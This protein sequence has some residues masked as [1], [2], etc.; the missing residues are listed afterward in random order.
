MNQLPNCQ[1]AKLPNRIKNTYKN[2]YKFIVVGFSAFR[3]CICNR[4]AHFIHTFNSCFNF[5]L[6]WLRLHPPHQC[7]HF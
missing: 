4:A 7:A 5:A 3:V 6:Q 1:I 2:K